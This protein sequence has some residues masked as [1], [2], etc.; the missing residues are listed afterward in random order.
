VTLVLGAFV[1][2]DSGGLLNILGVFVAEVIF[3]LEAVGDAD[4]QT[5]ISG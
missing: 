4:Y 1:E 2:P 3:V 5:L